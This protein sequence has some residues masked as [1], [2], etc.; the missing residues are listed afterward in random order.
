MVKKI[1]AATAILA[2]SLPFVA[3][4]QSKTDL[5]ATLQALLSQ[6]AALQAQLDA[7][8]AVPVSP[9]RFA[10][11]PVTGAAPFRVTFSYLMNEE[12]TCQDRHYVLNFGDETKSKAGYLT[13]PSGT[14][15]SYV[16]YSNRTYTKPGTYH[17]SLVLAD[18]PNV[19]NRTLGVATI[20]VTDPSNNLFVASPNG[21]EQVEVGAESAITW[22]PSQYNP[23]VNPPRDVKAYLEQKL[24]DGTF[25][26]LG[27]MRGEGKTHMQTNMQVYADDEIPADPP[28]GL[29]YVR[30]VNVQTGWWDRSD[31]AFTLVAKKN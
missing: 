7:K 9:P 15:H 10:V 22:S 1:F 17:T 20:I 24:P 11:S 13:K 31:G 12:K 30:I 8:Y 3:A 29:Y 25:Y 4:A 27:E 2:L 23:A 21:G 19:P 16:Q 18:V 14:C 5:Q 6:L 26:T 28:P